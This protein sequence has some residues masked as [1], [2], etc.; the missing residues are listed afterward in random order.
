MTFKTKTCWKKYDES[1]NFQNEIEH[2]IEMNLK[3]EIILK[4]NMM[5]AL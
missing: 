2:I 3:N 4:K 5:N 1:K